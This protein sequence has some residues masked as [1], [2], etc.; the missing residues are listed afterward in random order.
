LEC[1]ADRSGNKAPGFVSDVEEVARPTSEGPS[2]PLKIWQFSLTSVGVVTTGIA[3]V[4]G[5]ARGMPFAAMLVILGGGFAILLGR[6][7]GMLVDYVL[8]PSHSPMLDGQQVDAHNVDDTKAA[9]GSPPNLNDGAAP[10]LE[11]TPLCLHCFQSVSPIQ[12]YCP[13]C[14]QSIGQLTPYLPYEGIWFQAG[15][16]GKLWNRLW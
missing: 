16:W 7:L 3:L 13:H 4:V 15:M 2:R 12:H 9:I 1:G 5:L 8:G 6:F 10:S 11:Q 14:G